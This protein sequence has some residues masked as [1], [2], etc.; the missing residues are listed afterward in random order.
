MRRVVLIASVALVCSVASVMA[1]SAPVT[2]KG[3][4]LI[5]GGAL[6]TTED[7][8]ERAVRTAG[9]AAGMVVVLPQASEL[10]DT[11]QSNVQMW[12]KAGFGKAVSIDP[13][14]S[15]AALAAI[16]QA[17]FIWFPGGDQN[18]LTKAWAGTG[19][20]AA[21]RARYVEGALVGGSSAGAAVMSTVMITGEA[22]LQ[23]ITSGRT[24]LAPGFALWPGVLVDQH[25][26]KR[27]RS[28]RLISA[29][30]GHPDLVGVGID[31]ATAVF[32]SGRE[33]EVLGKS[34]VVVVDARTA[35]VDQTGAGQL[36][37]GRNLKVSVLKAGMRFSLD[38]E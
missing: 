20:P 30:L 33:F 11:G 29:V 13:K 32:V 35:E 27:Q 8:F 9:G 36:A 24:R 7:I 2:P 12:K 10:A 26:L 34:S 18:R 22:D 6:G 1:Q 25:F 15:A 23:S 16:E 21:I 31:E 14:H 38:R 28:N 19:I 37:T 5:V 17:T 3:H 4:L